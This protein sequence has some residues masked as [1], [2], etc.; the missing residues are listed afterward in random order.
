M[1]FKAVDCCLFSAEL[2]GRADALAALGVKGAGAVERGEVAALAA[3]ALVFVKQQLLHHL[4]RVPAVQVRLHKHRDC[5]LLDRGGATRRPT[6]GVSTNTLEGVT[7][8]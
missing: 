6:F 8:T 5:L 4:F 2:L 1:S 7:G 3:A